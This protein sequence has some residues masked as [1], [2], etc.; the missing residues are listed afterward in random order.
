MIFRVISAERKPLSPNS[1]KTT[2]TISGSDAGANPAN[3]AWAAVPVC[4]EPVLPAGSYAAPR[5]AE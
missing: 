1:A 3:H 5:K 2:T 4:A